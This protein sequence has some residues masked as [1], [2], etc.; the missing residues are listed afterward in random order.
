MTRAA[1]RL[2]IFTWIIITYMIMAMVWWGVLLFTKNK[3]AFEAKVELIKMELIFTGID[4]IEENIKSTST[5]KSLK[6]KYKKQEYMIYGE[7]IIFMF[8]LGIGI[9]LMNRGFVK[10]IKIA[11]IQ[12]NFLLSITHEL[13]SPL[14]G[15]KLI[16]ETIRKHDLDREKLN[17]LTTNGLTDTDRLTELVDNIL[18]AARIE[19]TYQPVFKPVNLSKIIE[20][21]IQ[22]QIIR[23]PNAIIKHNCP[24]DLIIEIDQH[25][26]ITVINNLLDNAIKYAETNPI[27]D[28]LILDSESSKIKIEVRDNGIGINPEEVPFIFEKFYRVGSEE[29]R[30]TKGTGLGLYIVKGIIR[31]HNG[32]IKV[33]NNFGV[34]SVLIIELPKTHHKA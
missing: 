25:G 5:Y 29:T 23:H 30:K 17:M 32:S 13:K 33:E 6:N 4:P 20:S 21:A 15:I 18:L 3:D 27:I 8:S 19:G 2:R 22:E 16:F 10:E 14:A 31:A 28:I 7:G 26:M 11:Q 9:W 1:G 34:G 12:K 24:S